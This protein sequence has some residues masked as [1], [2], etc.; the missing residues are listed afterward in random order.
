[1]LADYGAEVNKL[2]SRE[3]DRDALGTAVRGP[4]AISS[5]DSIAKAWQLN[6]LEE[7]GRLDLCLRLIDKMDVLKRTSGRARWTG[8]AWATKPCTSEILISSYCSISG[9]GQDGP[10]RDEAAMD[11]VVQGS[12]GLLSI[13]G[14]EQGESVRCGYG[15]T[16]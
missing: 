6:Q 15:V 11:L 16:T 10:S 3:G 1:L 14:T 13:T 4:R 12:S 9:Y 2:E 5:S 7:C 8:S